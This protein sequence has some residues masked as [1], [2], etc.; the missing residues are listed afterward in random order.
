MS[1]RLLTAADVHVALPWP[2]LADHLAQAF[3]DGAQVPVRHSDALGGPDALL[4]MPAWSDTV[5]GV[6]SIGTALEDLA[7]ARFVWRH[8][9]A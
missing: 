9:G 8:A 2:A 6:K 3:A 1:M 5:L 7:A 4:R